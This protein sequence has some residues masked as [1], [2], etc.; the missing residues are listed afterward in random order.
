MLSWA[1]R[2]G[3]GDIVDR[4]LSWGADEVM[5]EYGPDPY[6]GKDVVA[7]MGASDDE[8]EDG[9]EV[10]ICEAWTAETYASY[11]AALERLCPHRDLRGGD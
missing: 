3:A 9:D 7:M 6:P 11:M 10:W 4:L 5:P 8:E 2:F 1:A